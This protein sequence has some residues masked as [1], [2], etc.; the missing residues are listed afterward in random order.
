MKEDILTKERIKELLNCKAEIYC[1]ETVDSTNNEAKR[2]IRNGAAKEFLIVAEEQTAGRGRQGKTFYSP[3]KTGIYMSLT[4]YPAENNTVGITAAAA[5]AVCRAIERFSPEK[6]KIKW[7]NDVYSGGRKICGILCES[8]KN[9][10]GKTAVVIGIGINIKTANFP[11]YVENGGCIGTEIER[12]A[13]VAA[14]TDELYKTVFSGTESFIE[15]YRARS[16]LTGRKIT[17]SENGVIKTATAVGID[18]RCGLEVV[19]DNGERRVL[20][21]GE[22]SVRPE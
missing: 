20:V 10:E 9:A 22:I 13:L 4:V 12:A 5:V 1:F 3:A 16:M 15:E 11:G 7:V 19:L 18:S 8:L 21:S 2:R 17:F 14:V 6:T